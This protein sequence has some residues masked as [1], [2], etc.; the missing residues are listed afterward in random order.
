MKI[1]KIL[2]ITAFTILMLFNYSCD[3][4]NP[5]DDLKAIVQTEPL[6]TLVNLDIIDAKTKMPVSG[7][8]KITFQGDLKYRK[9]IS[10]LSYS[11]I[12]DTISTNPLEV[13]TV[14]ETSTGMIS[15]TLD[16]NFDYSEE[17]NLNLIAEAE[18]FLT[19]TIPLVIQAGDAGQGEFNYAFNMVNI[20]EAPDGVE[21]EVNTTGTT[22]NDGAVTETITITTTTSSTT[23]TNASVEIPTGTILLDSDGEP[24]K[25]QLTSS[26]IYYDNKSDESLQSLP[27]NLDSM[28]TG[29]GFNFNIYD[30]NGNEAASLSSG[31][32]SNVMIGLLINVNTT[33]NPETGENVKEGDTIGLWKYEW[34]G[35]K[36][37]SNIPLLTTEDPDY[38]KLEYQDLNSFG[39]FLI[40]WQLRSIGW[41][42]HHIINKATGEP[43]TIPLYVTHRWP[44]GSGAHTRTHTAWFDAMSN[45]KFVLTAYYN[46]EIV[47]NKEYNFTEDSPLDYNFEVDFG[48]EEFTAYTFDI[49]G[50]CADKDDVEIRPS[51]IPFR[52]QKFKNGAW[53]APEYVGTLEAGIITLEGIS[54][55]ESYYKITSSFDDVTESIILKMGDNLVALVDNNLDTDGDGEYDE[56]DLNSDGIS[57]G[58]SY[59]EGISAPVVNGSLVK[60][61]II[62]PDEVCEDL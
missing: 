2:S 57:E 7:D 11:F 12:S 28:V 44:G 32:K 27:G 18:G 52:L 40:G 4:K 26:L 30:E 10:N 36:K 5:T 33:F 53:T 55:T 61:V 45:V 59:T 16:E 54:T 60:F 62:P 47:G 46:G 51:G 37:L 21:I 6:K 24:L 41:T 50:I 19:Q 42:T 15:F 20:E 8:V 38:L 9:M 58:S 25:G 56:V 3:I 22:G 39:Y 43:N 14:L 23:N 35:W 29:G 34:G 1:K 17:I 31:S 48:N 49:T 13:V